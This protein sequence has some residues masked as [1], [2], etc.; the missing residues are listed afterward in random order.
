MTAAIHDDSGRSRRRRRGRREK[1]EGAGRRRGGDRWL[2]VQMALQE[3]SCIGHAIE[4]FLVG[5][6]VL[7]LTL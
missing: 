4:A 6:L 3:G 1:E 7:D 2:A 5:L